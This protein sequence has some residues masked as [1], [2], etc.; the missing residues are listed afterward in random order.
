MNKKLRDQGCNQIVT[1]FPPFLLMSSTINKEL[2][3]SILI[4]NTSHTGK[5]SDSG[6]T[7][8]LLL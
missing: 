4:Y 6:S 8:C 7:L 1:R 5:E 3:D 2:V